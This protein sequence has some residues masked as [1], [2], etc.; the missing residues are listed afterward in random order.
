M[1]LSIQDQSDQSKSKRKSDFESFEFPDLY[2]HKHLEI[3]GNGSCSKKQD[4]MIAPTMVVNTKGNSMN[5]Q[6]RKRKDKMFENVIKQAKPRTE[7]HLHNHQLLPDGIRMASLVTDAIELPQAYPLP[8]KRR[9]IFPETNSA[10]ARRLTVKVPPKDAT[11]ASGNAPVFKHGKK[12]PTK[13]PDIDIEIVSGKYQLVT[14]SPSHSDGKF[15]SVGMMN[16]EGR[17]DVAASLSNMAYAPGQK[18]SLPKN[19]H[20]SGSETLRR[21]IQYGFVEREIDDLAK[22]SMQTSLSPPQQS[23]TSSLITEVPRASE[24]SDPLRAAN[25]NQ[26]DVLSNHL[27]DF[28]ILDELFIP[29]SMQQKNEGLSGSSINFFH[30]GQMPEHTLRN[31]E[32][33]DLDGGLGGFDEI[34]NLFGDEILTLSF[35][36]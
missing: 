22:K 11:T 3:F 30:M 5:L 28:E 23:V 2:S 17:F 34:A 29:A 9:R 20:L 32:P 1:L 12:I 18:R 27:P 19:G 4:D 24:G 36:E 25:E 14:G 16:E 21:P 31:V 15:T 35:V 26:N 7:L 6:E 33:N 8:Q 10:G 13:Y